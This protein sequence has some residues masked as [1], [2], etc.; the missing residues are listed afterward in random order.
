MPA[1]GATTSG[2]GGSV[3]E[4]STSTGSGGTFTGTA[5]GAGGTR[6]D[7]ASTGGGASPGATQTSGASP[8]DEGGCG[9]RAR[10]SAGSRGAGVLLLLVAGLCWRR[11]GAATRHSSS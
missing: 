1:A 2:S 8:S 4:S 5:S 11:H 9:C 6:S 3:G 7:S 10:G